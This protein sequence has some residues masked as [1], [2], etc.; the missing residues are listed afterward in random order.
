MNISPSLDDFLFLPALLRKVRADHSTSSPD[1]PSLFP[2]F[3]LTLSFLSGRDAQTTL[4]PSLLLSLSPS[5][6]FLPLTF[7][8][9][10]LHLP[11]PSHPFLPPPSHFPLL[12][13]LPSNINLRARLASFHR[14]F[15]RKVFNEAGCLRWCWKS[16]ECS[17]TEREGKGV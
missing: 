6:A 10:D 3:S 5:L 17:E 1:L 15:N 2:S 16:V 11:S 7:E 12:P 14:C 4:T 13:S 9:Q 8:A